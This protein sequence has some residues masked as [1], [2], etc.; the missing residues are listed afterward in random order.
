M[1]HPALQEEVGKP[2]ALHHLDPLTPHYGDDARYCLDA[3]AKERR[4]HV[5]PFE[6][7]Q[8]AGNEVGGAEG[9]GGPIG[10]P[11]A[12]ALFPSPL[13]PQADED[14]GHDFPPAT[15]PSLP[16]S[17]PQLQ[18]EAV[19]GPRDDHPLAP[20]P[21]APALLP[22]YHH[23]ATEEALINDHRAPPLPY[24]STTREGTEEEFSDDLEMQIEGL[25]A[26]SSGPGVGCLSP[27]PTEV[28]SDMAFFDQP[29]RRI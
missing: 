13:G 15:A 3:V 11:P 14:L 18:C 27:D 8:K 21:A 20:A 9:G 22:S 7:W 19:A 29:P 25:A 2:G 1:G 24:P 4:L 17:F 6:E 10:A 16:T 12:P 26:E 5:L 23:G 28:M